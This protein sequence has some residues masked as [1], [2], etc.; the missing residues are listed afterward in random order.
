MI[1]E[2]KINSNCRE[3]RKNGGKISVC[4]GSLTVSRNKDS[5]V[6]IY[7]STPKSFLEYIFANLKR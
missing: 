5:S 1:K 4:M 6:L 2:K 7:F 3:V